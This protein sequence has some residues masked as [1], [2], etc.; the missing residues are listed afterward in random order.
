MELIIY[1]YILPYITIICVQIY[2]ELPDWQTGGKSIYSK[3]RPN[4]VQADGKNLE[5]LCSIR[6]FVTCKRKFHNSVCLCIWHFFAVIFFA[7]LW[8]Q[9]HV[10]EAKNHRD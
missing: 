2:V 6:L 8:G 1:K 3:P 5:C 9:W 7:T 4:T 10:Y